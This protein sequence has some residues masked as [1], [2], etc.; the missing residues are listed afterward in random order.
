M[1]PPSDRLNVAGVGVGGMGKVTCS[2]SASRTTSSRS[3]TWT[4]YAGKAWSMLPEDLKREED[5]P[6]K[7]TTRRRVRTVSIASLR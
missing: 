6:P 7:V 5:Q 3:A 4:D 1:T 2:T